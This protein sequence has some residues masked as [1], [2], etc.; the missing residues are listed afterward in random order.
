M[1]LQS[2]YEKTLR[3]VRQ[4][5][6]R[7]T[8]DI[9]YH[10]ERR[11]DGAFVYG[12]EIVQELSDGRISSAATQ[13][14]DFRGAPDA[15]ERY[16]I[17]KLEQMVENLPEEWESDRYRN[18]KETDESAVA[19]ANLVSGMVGC[20]PDFHDAEVLAVTLRRVEA[21]GSAHTDME[22]TIRYA[23]YKTPALSD[24]MKV[25]ITFLFESVEGPDF[26]IDNVAHPSWIYDLRFS[27][28][29]DGRIQIDLNPS[30]GFSILLY[31]RVATVTQVEPLEQCSSVG[32]RL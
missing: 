30:I 24:R 21:N 32:Q 23:W 13:M 29:G 2:N 12:C 10:L 27:H 28:C 6:R 31:C 15:A 18:R 4:N 17:G 3:Y 8:Y 7:L 11:D 5:E 25:R 22:L 19:R 14:L 1:K 16:L 20:W 9:G 26:S